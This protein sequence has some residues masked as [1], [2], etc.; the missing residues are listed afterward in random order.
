[1]LAI[2]MYIGAAIIEFIFVL[3]FCKIASI[4]DERLE[5]TFQE[6]INNNKD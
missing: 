2:I 6:H 4:E 3:A 5:K 1:M